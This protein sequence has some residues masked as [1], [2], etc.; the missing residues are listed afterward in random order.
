MGLC[1]CVYKGQLCHRL[2]TAF[3]LSLS[4]HHTQHA[5]LLCTF[6]TLYQYEHNLQAMC[7]VFSGAH[8]KTPQQFQ[9]SCLASFLRPKYTTV[10][11]K[12]GA[13]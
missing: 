9:S 7:N 5:A 4:F 13:K 6:E 3:A 8:L 11:Y 12:L 1:V 10:E 2:T